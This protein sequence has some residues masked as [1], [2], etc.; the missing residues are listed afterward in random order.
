MWRRLLKEEAATLRR[1]DRKEEGVFDLDWLALA[2]SALISSSPALSLF[3][4]S[5]IDVAS[6]TSTRTK[7]EFS[8]NKCLF[9]YDGFTWMNNK[10]KERRQEMILWCDTV[11][12]GCKTPHLSETRQ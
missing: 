2:G 7:E 11:G 3:Q 6:F 5:I 1:Y 10:N 9:P 12:A 8:K 4:P